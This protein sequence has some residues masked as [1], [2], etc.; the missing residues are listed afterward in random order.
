MEDLGTRC[1]CYLEGLIP[2]GHT[3]VHQP[4]SRDAAQLQPKR[5]LE[6][7]PVQ[8]AY[9]EHWTALVEA[10]YRRNWQRGHDKQHCLTSFTPICK[11]KALGLPKKGASLTMNVFRAKMCELLP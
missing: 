2:V 3:D 8:C 1:W 6:Q 5:H 10:L 4:W 7:Q 11:M 9:F